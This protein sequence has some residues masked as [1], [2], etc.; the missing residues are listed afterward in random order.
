MG[1]RVAASLL[2]AAA[3]LVACG[4]DDSGSERSDDGDDS[5]SVAATTA[6]TTP[7]TEGSSPPPAMECEQSLTAT[8]PDGSTAALDTGTAAVRLA[9]GAA[10][11]LYAGD[12][13][14]PT[15]N[16]DFETVVPPAGQHQVTI[17]VTVFNATT[18]PPPIEPGTEVELAS[19]S[20]ELTFGVVAY[21]GEEAFGEAED[22][23]GA[24]TVD[25]VDDGSICVNIDYVDKQKSVVGTLS[26]P[27]FDAGF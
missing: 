26:A 5:P 3:A 1:P 18:T 15:E 13:A 12:Y 27:V 14:V 10:Y 21:V 22:A 20:G 16:L 11:T 7:T 25:A 6:T 4:G 9:G 2:V 17:Y 24:L 8:F 19:G 23:T